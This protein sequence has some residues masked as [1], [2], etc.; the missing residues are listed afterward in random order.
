MGKFECLENSE[1]R[2]WVGLEELGI[3]EYGDGRGVRM[4]RRRGRR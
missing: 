1:G 4:R 2:G 3:G